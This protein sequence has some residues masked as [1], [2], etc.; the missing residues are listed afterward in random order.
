MPAIF[1]GELALMTTIAWDGAVLAADNA[2]WTGDVC[3]RDL[4]IEPIKIGKERFIIARCGAAAFTREC[5]R[6]MTGETKHR[7]DWSE[8][9][10]NLCAGSMW[11]LLIA[12]DGSAFQVSAACS[13]EKIYDPFFAMGAGREIALGALAAGATAIKA[14]NITE[15]HSGYA[16]YGVTAMRFN[17]D[18]DIV[19]AN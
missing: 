8:Y 5:I 11:G 7:P 2:A 18:G 4:K 15:Q 6:F 14:V 9:D 16:K 19:L 10:Q 1:S 17:D 3:Q 13:L 12:S